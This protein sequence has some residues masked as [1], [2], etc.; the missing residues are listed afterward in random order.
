M[1][2]N[3]NNIVAEISKEILANIKET[4]EEKITLTVREA[5][6]YTGIGHEKIRELIDIPNTDFPFFKVGSRVAINKTLLNNWL[7][8]ISEEHRQ[9]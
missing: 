2:S 6:L 8:R 5:A 1:N 9:L 4:K 7:D 3:R